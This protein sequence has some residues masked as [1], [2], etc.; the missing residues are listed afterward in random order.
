MY[1]SDNSLIEDTRLTISDSEVSFVVANGDTT[2]VYSTPTN[3]YADS[4]A[5]QAVV[6][7]IVTNVNTSK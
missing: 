2:E 1:T 5:I 3:D 4:L 7:D 6:E